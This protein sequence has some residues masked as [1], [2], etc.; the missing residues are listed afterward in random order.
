L[1]E[2]PRLHEEFDLFLS[3]AVMTSVRAAFLAAIFVISGTACQAEDDKLRKVLEGRYAAMKAAMANRDEREIAA[4][5]APDFV[6]AD[7]SGSEKTGAQ[8]IDALKAAPVNPDKMS[9][10]T[11]LS[12]ESN[13]GTATVKQRYNMKTVK[14]T[15]D[16]AKHQVELTTLSSDVWVSTGGTWILQRTQTDQM[17]YLVDGK[18]LVHKVRQPET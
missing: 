10:T 7:V 17:D 2:Q 1:R 16:G 11:L 4:L 8:M 6:S 12:V 18:P 14:A 13:G 15:P 9:N 5:L 3:G